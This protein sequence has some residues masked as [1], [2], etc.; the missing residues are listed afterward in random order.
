VC[1]RWSWRIAV[2]RAVIAM[3]VL[4]GLL[5]LVWVD[6]LRKKHAFT[7]TVYADKPWSERAQLV[8]DQEIAQ[9]AERVRSY[10]A[11]QPGTHRLLIGAESKYVFLKLIYALLPLD[12]A[13][14]QQVA[15]LR[16]PPGEFFVL[17]YSDS[18]WHYD[19]KR[20]AIVDSAGR[21]IGTAADDVFSG[22]FSASARIE[23]VF[24]KGD[25]RLY[26]RR[27]EGVSSP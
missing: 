24:E 14:L 25:L 26:V 22:N 18:P 27:D 2:V 19:E 12:A 13:P 17:L 15:Q 4:W 8:P 1:L 21:S 9:A 16:W 10:F 5:D 7:E 23:P 20:A 11:S 6:D 3:G